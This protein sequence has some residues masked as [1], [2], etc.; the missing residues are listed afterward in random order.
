MPDRMNVGTEGVNH[1]HE[2]TREASF[3]P[4]T[5]S[6]LL[7]LSVMFLLVL[8]LPYPL[9]CSSACCIQVIPQSLSVSSP[10]PL[11]RSAV[12]AAMHVPLAQLQALDRAWD[13]PQC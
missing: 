1:L 8:C 10:S 6:A 3:P 7:F 12:P 5:L 11:L 9:P 4:T 2:R 13:W